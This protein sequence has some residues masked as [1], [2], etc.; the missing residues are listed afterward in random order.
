MLSGKVVGHV[1][2]SRKLEAV[3]NGTLV[4]VELDQ[5]DDRIIAFDPLSCG[6]G[7]A[8]LITTGSTCAAFF[9][10]G[11]LIDALVIASLE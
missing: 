9:P 7:E 6:K 8:V 3:P 11:A 2:S 10:P 1:W 5:K 4:V